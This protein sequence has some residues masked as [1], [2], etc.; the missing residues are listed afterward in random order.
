[1]TLKIVDFAMFSHLDHQMLPEKTMAHAERWA[2]GMP[3][4]GY[5]IDDQTANKV[6]GGS[7]DVISE[8]YWT[9]FTPR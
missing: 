3:V 8:G 6:T 7:V 9:L 4:P 5:A 1:L 2:A